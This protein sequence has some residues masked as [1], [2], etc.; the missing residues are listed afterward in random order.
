M[1]ANNA[2]L[3]LLEEKWVVDQTTIYVCENKVCLYPVTTS[4]EAIKLLLD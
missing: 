2:D 1:T 4:E 3:E